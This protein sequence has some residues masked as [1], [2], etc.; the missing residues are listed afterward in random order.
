MVRLFEVWLLWSAPIIQSLNVK[1]VVFPKMERLEEEEE[2]HREF[3]EKA[4]EALEKLIK[5]ERIR[6]LYLEE[7]FE[8][9][10]I[11]N[12]FPE[13]M[14]KV[15]TALAGNTSITDLSLVTVSHFLW[16]ATQSD[17]SGMASLKAGLIK[18]NSVRRLRLG[19]KGAFR[20][21]DLAHLGDLLEE[22]RTSTKLEMLTLEA[23]KYPGYRTHHIETLAE[24]IRSS[25]LECLDIQIPIGPE[26]QHPPSSKPFTSP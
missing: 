3:C 7:S 6:K 18:N 11:H 10:K 20:G 5:K 1:I 15:F 13:Y 19:T 21:T 26:F 2:G 12:K 8:N 14:G 22:K 17:D 24:G 9:T 25:A 4:C 16:R 23:A